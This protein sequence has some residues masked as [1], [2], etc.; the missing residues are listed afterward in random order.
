MFV[1]TDTILTC[2]CSP[3]LLR[4]IVSVLCC[5]AGMQDAE[6]HE[7]DNERDY[8]SD[9]KPGSEFITLATMEAVLQ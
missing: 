4:N 5:E 9:K 8:P 7:T 6:H 3:H 1:F 2:N